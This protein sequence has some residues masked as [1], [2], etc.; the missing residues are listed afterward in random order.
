MSLMMPIA[1]R[2]VGHEAAR[3]A[4]DEFD[5]GILTTN[6]VAYQK[7]CRAGCVEQK[8][9]REGQ[10][11]ADGGSRQIGRMDEDH[12]RT[13]IQ[14]REQVVLTVLAQVDSGR[15]GQQDDAVSVQFVERP[16]NL[17]D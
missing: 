17:A 1:M 7:V 4:Q 8:I 6:F 10:N 12:R 13:C 9:R 16:D 11:T 3:V 14:R 2:G 5:V 15:V